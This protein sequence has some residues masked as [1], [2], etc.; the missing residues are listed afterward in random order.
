MKT[1]IVILVLLVAAA[2]FLVFQVS[3]PTSTR[4]VAGPHVLDPPSEPAGSQARD[5]IHGT[6]VVGILNPAQLKSRIAVTSNETDT[7][8]VEVDGAQSST[9]LTLPLGAYD[10]VASC[11]QFS[12]LPRTG[13]VTASPSRVEISI[14]SQVRVQLEGAVNPDRVYVW[15]GQ[16][17]D[18]QRTSSERHYFKQSPDGTYEGMVAPGTYELYVSRFGNTDVSRGAFDVISESTLVKI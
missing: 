16:D 18:L 12:T 11:G 8:I 2:L 13:L 17:G 6:L 4:P 9:S 5:P 3:R 15:Y 1:T 7:T 14:A 10:L